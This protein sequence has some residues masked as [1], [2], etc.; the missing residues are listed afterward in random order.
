MPKVKLT[1]GQVFSYL[2]A[3]EPYWPRISS[4][5]QNF[6]QYP[7][8]CF[9]S[10]I[11]LQDLWKRFEFVLDQNLGHFEANWFHHVEIVMQAISSVSTLKYRSTMAKPDLTTRDHRA[12]LVSSNRDWF[13]YYTNLYVYAG[14]TI[15]P[16]RVLAYAGAKRHKSFHKRRSSDSPLRT[17]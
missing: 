14:E 9:C 8:G 6:P 1:I 17:L 13:T 11:H 7:L 3:T 2:V 5:T 15:M 4:I 12:R 10:K 16:P